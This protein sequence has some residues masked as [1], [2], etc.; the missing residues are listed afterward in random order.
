MLQY[1]LWSGSKPHHMTIAGGSARGMA[2]VI[3]SSP[4]TGMVT[5]KN[6]FWVHLFKIDKPW[7]IEFH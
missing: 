5:N 2:P 3:N 1:Y 4:S 6:S 7:S